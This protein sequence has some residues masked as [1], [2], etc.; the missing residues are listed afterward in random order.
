MGELDNRQKLTSANLK[1]IGIGLLIALGGSALTY[2][3]QVIG[4][5]DFGIWTPLVVT[6]WSVIVNAVRKYFQNE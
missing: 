1:S 5:V 3:T 2:L 6:G 4:S